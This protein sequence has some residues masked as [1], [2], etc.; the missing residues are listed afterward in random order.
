ML[1][2]EGKGRDY[3][4]SDCVKTYSNSNALKYHARKHDIS[5]EKYTCDVCGSQF[6][7]KGALGIHTSMIHE[8]ETQNPE[9][10]CERCSKC[11]KFKNTLAR[12]MKERHYDGNVNLDYVALKI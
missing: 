12:H 1:E 8:A 10:R 3:R 4:C 11:F 7:S 5:A 9:F 2:H 6:T